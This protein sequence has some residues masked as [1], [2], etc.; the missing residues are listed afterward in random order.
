LW[1]QDQSLSK[2][3]KRVAP[4]SASKPAP[5]KKKAKTNSAG[6]SGGSEAALLP[7][8]PIIVDKTDWARSFA[9]LGAVQVS[10]RLCE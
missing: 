8:G 5:S 1:F 3:E 2:G 6:A 7:K 10:R 4:S 9:E